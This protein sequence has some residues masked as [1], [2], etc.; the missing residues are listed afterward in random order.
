MCRSLNQAAAWGLMA[1]AAPSGPTTAT[2]GGSGGGGRLC[3]RT[4]TRLTAR[5]SGWAAAAAAAAS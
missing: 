5:V 4:L 1:S 2:P 3:G